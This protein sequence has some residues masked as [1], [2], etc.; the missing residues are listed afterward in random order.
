MRPFNNEI[1]R[2]LLVLRTAV[3]HH[4]GIIVSKLA[5]KLTTA[6]TFE[7]QQLITLLLE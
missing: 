4:H 1:I 3:I 7:L 6:S 5:V 2:L